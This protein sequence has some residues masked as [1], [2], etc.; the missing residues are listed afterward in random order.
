[1]DAGTAIFAGPAPLA[2][3]LWVANRRATA[4]R[5][6]ER[7]AETGG[8]RVSRGLGMEATDTDGFNAAMSRNA[9][10]CGVPQELQGLG[11]DIRTC[12]AAVKDD[13]TYASRYHAAFGKSEKTR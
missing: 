10:I 11:R 12:V 9:P 8:Y 5:A 1:M 13:E 3:L 7:S 2:L 6:G 4:G